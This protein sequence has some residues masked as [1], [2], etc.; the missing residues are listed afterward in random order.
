MRGSYRFLGAL[1]G[2]GSSVGMPPLLD[3]E[4]P[5][6]PERSPRRFTPDVLVVAG[7]LALPGMEIENVWPSFNV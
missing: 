3:D 1:G 7:L 5:E 4:S 2:G 6:P